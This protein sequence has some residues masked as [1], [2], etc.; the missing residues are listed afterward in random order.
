MAKEY[1]R[2]PIDVN[3]RSNDFSV[4]GAGATVFGPAARVFH[5][6]Y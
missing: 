2:L 6:F 4:S 1:P 3:D 5:A